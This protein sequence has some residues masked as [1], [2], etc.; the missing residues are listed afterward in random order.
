MVVRIRSESLAEIMF[1]YM[2]IDKQ[3]WRDEF[4]G[5]ILQFLKPHVGA[6]AGEV[7]MEEPFLR[8]ASGIWSGRGLVHENVEDRT[9]RPGN[10]L[11]RDSLG[12][13]HW[14]TSRK[15]ESH[16]ILVAASDGFPI[17]RLQLKPFVITLSGVLPL[18]RGATKDLGSLQIGV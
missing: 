10:G 5:I 12:I 18:V 2:A 11:S 9:G 16:V 13:G 1:S 17:S 4:L 6:S 15:S 3:Y 14:Q 7:P 8:A